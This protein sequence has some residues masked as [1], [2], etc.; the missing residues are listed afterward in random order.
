MNWA[1]GSGEKIARMAMG[2]ARGWRYRQG[3]GPGRAGRT[4]GHGGAGLG[5]MIG[6]EGEVPGGTCERGSGANTMPD[7]GAGRLG[8]PPGVGVSPSVVVFCS[9]GFS[10]PMWQIWMP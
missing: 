10:H 6:L 8:C 3:A 7:R 4:R 9:F 1:R 2:R 5:R